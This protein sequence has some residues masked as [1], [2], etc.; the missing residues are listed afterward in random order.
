MWRS[1]MQKT[2]ALFSLHSGGR[3]PFCIR[4]DSAGA[5]EVKYLWSVL[6]RTGF[7]QHG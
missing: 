6:D 7:T 4:T 3:A 2:T 1:E 5:A